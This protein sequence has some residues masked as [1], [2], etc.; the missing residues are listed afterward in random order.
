M[1]KDRHAETQMK[2]IY[3]FID[4]GSAESG[5]RREKLQ[6]GG[7]SWSRFKEWA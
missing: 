6:G 3:I 5:L 1:Q 7:K 4:N 2:Y